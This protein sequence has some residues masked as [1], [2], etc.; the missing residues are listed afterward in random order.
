MPVALPELAKELLD[1]ST[2]VVLSTLNPD[3]SPQ[4]SVVWA[5]REGDEIVFSTILGRRKTKNM[6]RD[7]RIS[8][9]AYDPA[10]PY[11]YFEARGPVRMTQEGGQELINRL[12]QRYLSGP[13]EEYAPDSVRVV[14][15]LA[16]TSVVTQPL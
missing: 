15:R 10:D 8:I 16:P 14:C 2:F 13:Y 7:P 4:S 1:R 9:C 11:R 5:M 12:A 6:A 3:G